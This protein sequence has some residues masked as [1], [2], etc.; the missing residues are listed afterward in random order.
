MPQRFCFPLRA[1]VAQAFV[2]TATAAAAQQAIPPAP[3]A[4]AA[5]AA[6]AAPAVSAAAPARAASAPPARPRPAAAASAPSATER[7]EITGGRNADVD[8]RRQ[9]TAAKIVIG[10]EEIDKFGD[11]TVGEVLRRLPGVS[12]PGA[13]GRGGP[14]RMRG[15]GNGF[16]QLLIDGQR[17]PPGFSIES[18]TPE[19][20]ERIEILRAPTAET[21]AQAIAGTINI[22]TREGFKRRLNDLRGGFGYENGKLSPGLNWTHNDS[23]GDLTYN[24]SGSAFF[25][26]RESSNSTRTTVTTMDTGVLQED[27]TA[28][29][30]TAEKRVGM[31]LTSRLQWRLGAADAGGGDQFALTPSVFHTEA[32]SSTRFSLVKQ[33]SARPG[34]DLYDHGDTESDSRF[35]NARLGLQWRQ[36]VGPVR[37]ELNGGGGSF[38]AVTNSLRNEFGTGNRTLEDHTTVREKSVNLTFKGTGVASGGDAANASEHNLVSGADID[39]SRRDENKVSLQN[40]V[41]LLV[42]YGSNLQA[43]ALRTAAYVQDEWAIN[44]N[45]AVQGGLRWEGINTRGDNGSANVSAGADPN[46]TNRSSVWTPL[47]HAVWKPDAKKRDQ[48][49]LSLTRSYRPPALG[50]LIARPT[51]NRDYPTTVANTETSP[52]NAGNPQLKPE[53]ASGI[54]LAFERYLDGGGVLSANL[55]HREISNLMRGVTRLET[56]SYSPL[57]RYVRRQQNVGDATTSGLEM[58]AKLRLDQVVTGAPGVELRANLSLY[59]SRVKSVPGPDNRLDQQAKATGNFGGDYRLRGVPLTLGGNI[60]WVPGYTTK[61]DVGQ[62]VNVTDKRVWDAYALWTFSPTVGL[63]MLGNNLAPRDYT[64]T[65]ISELPG[66]TGNERTT[67]ASTGP[68]YINW[69]LRLELKL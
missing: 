54:D 11:A 46:P 45:W 52:D 56:V 21:G 55:F 4:P 15:L 33:P 44:P 47:F 39:L 26:R 9:S 3:A 35:T 58:D 13:P 27:R 68:S 30:V 63:R 36:R 53:L 5:S 19:Q 23:A 51:I 62:F 37:L 67:V 40:S 1:A 38:K 49:R 57:Q 31:N 7:I 2:L 65:S 24:L 48:V 10:R 64:N 42:D 34:P 32:S 18:L 17:V 6:P 8:E 25:P 61:T 28:S 59:T 22:I 43:Q 29:S 20:V 14:P 16:T 12:T 41:P 69:Q 66:Q 60:N 50:T